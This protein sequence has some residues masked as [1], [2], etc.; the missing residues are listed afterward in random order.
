MEKELKNGMMK[1]LVTIELA[2][3]SN[4][5]FQ[6]AKLIEQGLN[7]KERLLLL[8]E[9]ANREKELFNKN[10]EKAIYKLENKYE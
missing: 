8:N 10:K 4:I 6:N 9:E 1:I 5:E 7:E 2:I 3:L